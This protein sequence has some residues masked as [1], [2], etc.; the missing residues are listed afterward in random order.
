VRVAEEYLQGVRCP[1]TDLDS[2]GVRLGIKNFQAADIAGSGELKK[3]SNGLQIFYS[4]Y[5][6]AER[7][8]F[9]IAHELGHAVLE[10][11]GPNVPRSG[12]EVER[13]CDMF[14]VE[15]LMPKKVFVD[16]ARGEIS[17]QRILEMARQFRTSVTSTGLR[18]AELFGV[19]VF[20]F[21]DSRVVWGKGLFTT[22]K[23]TSINEEFLSSIRKALEGQRC[24]DE[25]FLSSDPSFRRWHIE[26][27]P[28][29]G[30]R[31]VLCLLRPASAKN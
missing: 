13:I 20:A 29:A 16:C 28:L 23:Q 15:L 27:Q 25:V 8:R 18:Y 22:R 14:A 31:S 1:P 12:K 7:R 21:Q 24:S 30:G 10:T 26:C 3:D 19:S 6:S 11:T 4:S 5:L 9:T 17:T 2:I